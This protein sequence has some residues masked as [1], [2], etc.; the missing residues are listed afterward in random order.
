MDATR[1]PVVGGVDA[2]ISAWVADECNRV[3]GRDFWMGE[4]ETY[5]D[6]ARGAKVK[7]LG[8][9]Q[10]F[11]VLE[12]SQ[13]QDVLKKVVQTRWVLAWKMMEG[14]KIINVRSA[15]KGYQGPDLKEGVPDASGCVSLRSSHL[16]VISL[17]AIEKWEIWS[18]DTKAAFWQAD[19][20]YRD[21]FRRAPMEWSP[22]SGLR[23]WKLR[24]PT[25]GLNAAPVAS[26]RSLEKHLLDS[27]DSMEEV[28][29]LRCQVSSSRPCPFFVFRSG[30]RTGQFYDSY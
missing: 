12:P 16:Q 1:S 28:G 2:A 21:V 25:N 6:L 7:E 5:A 24:A 17:C 29:L 8:A 14:A 20:F 18:L 13:E 27:V 15:S 30:R 9:R 3:S 23:T 4:E 19:R 10:S 26:Y 22:L 11:G